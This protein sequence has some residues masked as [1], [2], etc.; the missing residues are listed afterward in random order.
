MDIT[1]RE[2][3]IIKLIIKTS[4]KHTP[5]SIAD[6]LKVSVRTVHRDLNS[7]EKM[8]ESFG[9]RLVRNPDKGLMIN[10]KNEQIFRLIQYLEDIKP[11]DE[12]PQ[13]KMLQLLLA[14]LEE[15]SYKIHS[16]SNH[17][18]VS[19]ATISGY[20]DQLTE[21]LGDYGVV[22]T[23]K[24]G[25]GVELIGSESNKRKALAGYILQYFYEELIEHLFQLEQGQF[26]QKMILYYFQTDYLLAIDRIVNS[27]FHHLHPRLADSDYIRFM[28]NICITMQ[29]TKDGFLLEEEVVYNENT[30]EYN[31]ITTISKYIEGICSVSF[32][33]NDLSYLAVILKGSKL[34]AV[35]AAPYDSIVLSQKIKNFIQD[36]S[37]QINVD[38]TKDFSLNQGLLAHMEP[39]LFRMKHQM[40]SYNPLTEDIKRKYPLLFIAVKN[41]VQKEFNEIE[42]FPDDEIAFI[43]LHFGS[44]L[45]MR[46]EDI[47]VNALIVCPTGIGTSKMLASRIKKEIA[48]IDAVEICSIKE[49]QRH[50]NL[51]SFDIIIST[52]S[53]PFIGIDYVLVSPL[54]TDENIQ[55]IKAYITNNI[56]KITKKKHYI[57]PKPQSNALTSHKLGLPEILDDLADV[58]QSIQSVIRHF[59][60]LRFDLENHRQVIE[61]MVKKAE[62]DQLLSDTNDIIEALMER[63]R[64]GGLGI[65]NTGM[66]LFHC[67]HE[68]VNEL[69]FQISHVNKPILI[70]G[71]DGKNMYMKN[72][73]LMLAPEALSV[74]QQEIVSLISTSLIENNDS[75]MIFSSADENMIRQKLETVFLDYLYTHVI[76]ND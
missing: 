49:I 33:K 12:T 36:V 23:R 59:H 15:E 38:L 44:A 52:V 34:Q 63:E 21:W 7:I 56:E 24:R 68:K 35:D 70:K 60:V 43:A 2:K 14:L 54:L 3:S 61:E 62:E 9:L 4:G 20:L 42:H 5:S 17:L 11:V 13:E 53:L 37:N 8:L 45:L 30:N 57:K 41:S 10:G 51:R 67:R 72:L 46:E 27:I 28:I 31:L 48:E 66:G 76:R 58:K 50:E 71:M 6:Y 1:S 74:R 26:S 18:G 29:R 16:L 75:I 40:E 73:L 19:V 47:S 64:K 69:I 55:A 65:P 22:I 32:T 25:V 39:S